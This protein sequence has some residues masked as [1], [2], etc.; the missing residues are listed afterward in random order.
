MTE[1]TGR[2]EQWY[3][4]DVGHREID[5]KKGSFIIWGMMHDDIRD[6]GF[7]EF[8]TSLILEGQRIVEGEVVETLNSRYLLGKKLKG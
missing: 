1:I 3:T 8:H 7:D 5:G 6:R 2:I 4:M